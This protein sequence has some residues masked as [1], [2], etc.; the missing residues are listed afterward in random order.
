MINYRHVLLISYPSF[1]SNICLGVCLFTTLTEQHASQP[2]VTPLHSALLFLFHILE[3]YK[4]ATL[5]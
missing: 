4:L 5:R 3:T 1:H 2:V